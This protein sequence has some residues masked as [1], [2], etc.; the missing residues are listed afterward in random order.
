MFR[1]FVAAFVAIMMLLM[2]APT[3][4]FAAEPSV[5]E[6]EALIAQIG[7]VTRENRSAV[8][9]AVDAYSQLNDAAKAEVSNAEVLT[10]AQQI[11]GIKDALAKLDLNYD[12]VE[13]SK[14]WISPYSE[15]NETNGQC[16]VFLSIGINE[17]MDFPV[18][19]LGME[20][21]GDYEL[22]M[23]V[24]KVRAGDNKYTYYR[25]A[26]DR[27]DSGYMMS[28]GSKKVVECGIRNAT[29]FDIRVLR[30]ILDEEESIIRFRR[31]GYGTGKNVDHA[32]TQEERQALIDVINAYGLMCLAEPEALRKAL[33]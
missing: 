33:M 31:E 18:L 32:V 22:G 24:V 13:H 6:V 28:N 11:L 20:Y 9:R 25:D 1:K 21:I 14:V 30:D 15:A 2:L 4:A 27:I 17:D 23:N 8:E 19:V 12:K 7:T 29:E 5:Q 3:S 10:E 16:G 26:F